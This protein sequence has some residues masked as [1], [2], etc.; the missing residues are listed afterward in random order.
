MVAKQKDRTVRTVA[1]WHPLGKKYFWPL[2]NGIPSHQILFRNYIFLRKL[3]GRHPSLVSFYF[4]KP[5]CLYDLNI[6][7]FPPFD[8]NILFVWLGKLFRKRP[9]LILHTS[10]PDHSR[11]YYFRIFK[12][13]WYYII[14][15]NFDVIVTPNPLIVKDLESVYPDLRVEFIPHPINDLFCTDHTVSR[16][17]DLAFIGEKSF[18]KGFDRFCNILSRDRSLKGI[19]AGLSFG[20]GS[21]SDN[22]NS[23]GFMTSGE[24]AGILQRSKILIV[25]SRRMSGWEE[26]FGIVIV[27]ALA[28]GCHVICS[29]HI[30]PV[31][32]SSKVSCVHVIPDDDDFEANAFLLVN[33]LK[34]SPAP[35]VD[36]EFVS[37]FREAAVK[38]RWF[39]IFLSI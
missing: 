36:H 9:K 23:N 24:I 34:Q 10:Y 13:L 39:D 20:I 8:P 22:H 16:D 38:Q 3:I 15:R 18:K 7:C 28:C 1:V 29:D 21:I 6:L 4:A 37:A 17:F 30:G 19:S 26:L 32:L 11:G 25:P 31:Y 33:I 5:V 14:C 2:T 27:E 35:S 12:R